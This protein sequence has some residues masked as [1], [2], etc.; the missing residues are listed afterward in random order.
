MK[1][2]NGDWKGAW[3]QIKS[4][5]STIMNNIISY[6]KGIDLA[7]IGKQIIQ[8]SVNGLGSMAGAVK[9]KVKQLA[10]LVP[11]GLKSLLGIHSPSRVTFA[12]GEFTGE[13]LING[14]QS[15]I[16]EMKSAA[17]NMASAIVPDVP[18]VLAAPNAGVQS[19]QPVDNTQASSATTNT[20]P[21]YITNVLTLDG[22]EVARTTAPYIDAMQTNQVT[23][24]S[25]MK[26][27]KR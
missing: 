18:A 5:A 16:N 8:G 21:V 9:S 22:Y 26:G 25:Y 27:D 20:K 19:L 2:L 4:T 11:D 3:N 14:V 6:F 12:L 7:S 24:N 17:A 10:S 13:G 1:V 15:K 23:L